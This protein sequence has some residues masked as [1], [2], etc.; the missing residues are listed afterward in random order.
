MNPSCLSIIGLSRWLAALVVVMYHV[1]FLLFVDYGHVRE[2]GLVVK[3]FYFLTSFGH[4]AFVIYMVLSGVLL[5]GLSRRRWQASGAQ[6]W[7]DLRHRWVRFSLLLIPALVVGGLLDLIGSHSF[8]ASTVYTHH[9]QFAPSHLSLSALFG[10]LLML[11][12]MAVPGFGS[13][14]MLFLLGFECWAYLIFALPFL[15]AGQGRYTGIAA[16][17]ALAALGTM[18]TQEFI[19]YLLL[20]MIG[21]WIASRGHL[22]RRAVVPAAAGAFVAALL[23]SRFGGASLA[24]VP[25]PLIP[26]ARI[27]LDLLLGLGFAAMLC[28]FCWRGKDRV[29][30]PGVLLRLNRRMA[31][32]SLTVYTVHFPFMMLFVASA[33]MLL[34]V[35]IHSQPGPAGFVVF[36][37]VVVAIYAYTLLFAGW[38]RPLARSAQQITRS[39]LARYLAH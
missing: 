34:G 7:R 28:S 30:W 12:G 20:W 2:R 31:K 6:P 4:E 22:R 29:R 3:L 16:G 17:C 26:L 32:A 39:A 36:L 23:L 13:N 1:R 37:L 33:N 21:A 8:A 10:N 24:S 19:G 38:G 15:L 14:A 35:P 5:G 18:L 27:A 9:P 11:Q 25:A